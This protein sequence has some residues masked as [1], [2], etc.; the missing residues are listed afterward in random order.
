MTAAEI[1]AA[2]RA[3]TLSG[4]TERLA[5]E[6]VQANLVVVPREYAD[7]LADLCARNPVPCPLLERLAAG[8]FEPNCAPGADL[9]TDLGRYRV[10]REGEL[11]EQPREVRAHWTG[12]LVAFLIGCSFTFDHALT[13]AN[14]PARHYVLNCNVPM[15]RTSVPLA[16][17]GRLRGTMVVSMRPYKPA[18]VE[19]VRDV[20]RPYRIG[21]GEPVAWGD[22]AQFGIADLMRPDYGDPPVLE[23]GDV[24]VFWGCGVTPQNVIVASGVPFAITHE[25][26]HMFVTDLLHT[27][28]TA[29]QSG[30]ASRP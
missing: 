30:I 6:R 14:L 11:I 9:R 10:W 15:Y 22:P 5:P 13:Q 21:H 28:M 23:P 18:D 16:P 8:A 7:E 4:P 24:P 17:A 26:G 19:R 3:G 1:R 12:D 29:L 27:D 20:T 25:P 2:I